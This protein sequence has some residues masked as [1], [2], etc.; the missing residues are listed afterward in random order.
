MATLGS[1]ATL[2]RSK[3][4]G[5]WVLTV[6]VMLP[7]EATYRRVVDSRAITQ[8]TMGAMFG[9]D[10][11]RVRVYEY[12][13]ATSIKVSIPRRIANGNPGDADAFGGQQ[14]APLVDLDI[15]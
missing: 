3:N 13:P 6:D 15:P 9:L 2:I 11:E 7:D 8:E 10:P 5:S 4:A 12:A 1:L 14:F